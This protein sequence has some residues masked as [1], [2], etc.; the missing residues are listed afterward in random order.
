MCILNSQIKASS[1]AT[2]DTTKG[3]VNSKK[4][5]TEF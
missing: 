1:L 3:Q 5:S 2:L 4:S